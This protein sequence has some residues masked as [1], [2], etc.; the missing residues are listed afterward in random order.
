MS[1]TY[2]V[3]PEFH[4]GDSLKAYPVSSWPYPTSEG[5]DGVAPT[6][7][8][9][10]TATVA[11]DSTV[12]FSALAAGT[13]YW[14]GTGSSPYPYL[15]VETPGAAPSGGSVTISGSL[16]AGT[17]NIG[18]VDVLTMPTVTTKHAGST[19]AQTIVASTT[20]PNTTLIA[21][22]ASR[23]GLTIFNDS[24][25]D[26]FVLLGAGTESATVWTHKIAAGGYY[27][28]PE[29]F[30]TMRASGHWTTADGNARITAAT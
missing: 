12:T 17:N 21:A 14:V 6:V 30:V 20:T 3:G 16:P 4:A 24:T 22:N 28:V 10:E 29:A 23:F 13:A 25:S 19:G 5:P 27:E 18:D 11:S 1:V 8:A 15:R 2:Q 9:T 7:A 26:L